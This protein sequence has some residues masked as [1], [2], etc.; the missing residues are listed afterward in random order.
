[1][2]NAN[3]LYLLLPEIVL[4]GV[5]TWIFLGGALFP[6]RTSWSWTAAAGVILAAFALFRQHNFGKLLD[7][8]LEREFSGPIVMDG[9]ALA[10][11]WGILIAGLLFVLLASQS[12][13]D[14]PAA[15]YTGS[16]LLIVAGLMLTAVANEL[17]LLFLGLELVSIP[18]YVVLYLGRRDA[19]GQESTI[20]YFFLSI[21]SSAL[22]LY[23]FSFLY[24]VAGSTQLSIL[25]ERLKENSD[26]VH[27]LLPAAHL[28]LV[29]VFVG[30]GFRMAAVP[31]HFY[32][33]DVYQGASNANAGLLSTLPKIAGLVGLTRVIVASMPESGDATGHMGWKIAVAVAVLTM[34]VGNLLALWQDNVRRLLAYSSIAHGGYMLIGVAVALAGGP[35][36]LSAALL[37]LAVYIVAT[38]GAFAALAYLGRRGRQIDGLDELAGLGKTHPLIASALVLFMFSLAGV[39]PLAGFWGKFNLFFN[40]LGGSMPENLRTWFIVLAVIGVLNSAISLGYYLRVVATMYFRPPLAAHKGQG[41]LGAF[42]ATLICAVLALALGLF[43]GP[44]TD[45]TRHAGHAALL[46]APAESATPAKLGQ[47]EVPAALPR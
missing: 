3:T 4:I 40:A 9:F 13:D 41:G 1:M 25:Y 31:F 11:R 16:L 12:E 18:T 27:A 29:L 38:T 45:V 19:A 8:S 17:T 47:L 37:Y 24:G 14:P 30:L 36:G 32:A 6:H 43:P 23:G 42:S 15:E 33:P 39:P 22:L 44:L 7:G 28:G 46:V 26:A 10:V 20:K 34:T 2:I 21:L 35:E 5:A